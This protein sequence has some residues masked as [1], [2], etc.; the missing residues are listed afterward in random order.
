[1][2]TAM[3][4]PNWM[5]AVNAVTDLSSTLS[6]ISPSATVR[7]PVLETG[8]NSVSPSMTPSSPA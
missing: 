7:C 4:A 6:P 2:N 8:R 5:T 1:M 3:I